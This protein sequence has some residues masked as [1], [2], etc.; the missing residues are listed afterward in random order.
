MTSMPGL[1]FEILGLADSDEHASGVC[2]ELTRFVGSRLPLLESDW[3]DRGATVPELIERSVSAFGIVAPAGAQGRI[4]MSRARP[5]SGKWKLGCSGSFGFGFGTSPQMWRADVHKQD[6]GG[7][8][9]VAVSLQRSFENGQPPPSFVSMFADIDDVAREVA[10]H[11]HVFR[12]GA[13]GPSRHELGLTRLNMWFLDTE[14]ADVVFEYGWMVVVPSSLTGRLGDLPAG[15]VDGV[16]ELGGR[17]PGA[18]LVRA[19][20][21]PELMDPAE[22]EAWRQAFLPLLLPPRQAY[23]RAEMYRRGLEV[24]GRVPPGISPADWTATAGCLET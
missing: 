21:S 12:G 17:N 8:W 5:P 20:V 10:R 6:R 14:T 13:S 2:A 1:R 16:V 24:Y 4:G 22:L 11:V 9:E 7:R 15:L 3:R 23:D 18:L 19:R